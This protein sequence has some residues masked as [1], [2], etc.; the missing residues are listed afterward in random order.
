MSQTF[1]R[2]PLSNF[3]FWAFVLVSDFD[4]RISDLACFAG[5]G[6]IEPAWRNPPSA[7]DFLIFAFCCLI[8]AFLGGSSRCAFGDADEADVDVLAAAGLVAVDG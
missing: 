8:F 4:I 3:G 7:D 6:R 1:G 5:A 2:R